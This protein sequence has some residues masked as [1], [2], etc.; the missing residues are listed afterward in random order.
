MAWDDWTEEG[1]KLVKSGE[2]ER[3]EH[4]LRLAL[5]AS[6]EFPPEDYRR[7]A[8]VTNLG[9]LLYETGRLD[10]AASLVRSAL[11]HHRSHLGARHPYVVRALANLAMI[12]HAQGRLEDAQHLY[13]ASLH[14]TDPD[15][16]DEESLRTMISL[17]ELYQDLGRT[18][19][20]LAMVDQA[21]LGL[22]DQADPM[23]RAMALSTRADVLMATGRL[24]LA[25]DSLVEMVD[26]ARKTLGP[27]HIDTSY[28][29]ND[30]G[31][32]QLQLDRAD[33]AA[34]NFRKVLFIRER[35]L[36]AVHPAVASAWNN[37]GAALMRQKRWS[38]AEEA[39]QQAIAIWTETLGPQSSETMAAKRSLQRITAENTPAPQ[40]PPTKP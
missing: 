13:E 10:E 25:A 35:A 24:E 27:N 4:L 9:G 34:T 21:L 37:L 32:V 26:I 40:S 14:A 22:G 31:L 30:L 3:A 1:L 28:P 20:A 36:G 33:H 23:D 6:L 19:E 7:P 17:A 15:D 8:S 11:E 29:L 39:L 12:A 18:E 2:L 38:E 5:D 16:F